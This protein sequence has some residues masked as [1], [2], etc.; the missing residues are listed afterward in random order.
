MKKNTKLVLCVMLIC[1]LCA[2]IL[3]APVS[4]AT[5]HTHFFEQVGLAQAAHPHKINWACECGATK[6]T[7]P[8]KSTCS[9]CRANEKT[10]TKTVHRNFVFVYVDGDNGMGVPITAAADCYVQYTNYYAYPFSMTYNYPPFASFSSIVNSY[11]TISSIHPTLKCI[12]RTSVKYYTSS[13]SLLSTQ[14]MMWN[15]DN[16][17]IPTN[18][19]FVYT[20]NSKPSYTIAGATFSMPQSGD[21][22]NLDATTYFS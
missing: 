1:A 8:L 16:N 17:A 4:A 3:P 10:A 11:A 14:S 19:L 7:Y 20:L 5:L 6:V 18:P 2:C 15:S 22:N 21:S 9:T 12:S 13:A